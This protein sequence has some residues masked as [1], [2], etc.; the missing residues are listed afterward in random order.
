MG[1]LCGF[2]LFFAGKIGFEFFEESLAVRRYVFM[3]QF[4]QFSEKVFFLT[5]DFSWNFDEGPDHQI[6]AWSAAWVGHSAIFQLEEM[7]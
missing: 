4:G 2:G 6:A 7:S 3:F 1:C 5:A